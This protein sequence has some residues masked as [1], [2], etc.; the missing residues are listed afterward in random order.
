[1]ESLRTSVAF[2]G[3]QG[4]K[5]KVQSSRFKVCP[6]QVLI[7]WPL[8]SFQLDAR[9]S[10]LDVR[11]SMLDVRCSMFDARCS[12]LDV[13]CSM[14]DV[15]CSMFGTSNPELRTLNFEPSENPWVARRPGN[16]HEWSRPWTEPVYGGKPLT[17]WLAI[18]HTGSPPVR[19]EAEEAVR[20]IGTNSIPFL[21][22][23]LCAYD[24]ALKLR[25][26]KFARRHQNFV[27][28]AAN[29]PA[30]TAQVYAA[31]GFRVLG[32]NAVQA[33]PELVKILDEEISPM[34]QASTAV[35]FLWIGPPARAAVPSLL[36]GATATNTEVRF[37]S[38]WALGDIHA[39]PKKVL[40]VL[41]N[42][43]R[44]PHAGI[45]KQAIF[46]VVS[47]STDAGEMAPAISAL[48]SDP[49]KNVRDTARWALT[50]AAIKN[51]IWSPTNQLQPR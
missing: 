3:V 8:F 34:S 7:C 28:I 31:H 2:K 10:M 18:C 19:L 5:F 27:K 24:L 50:N 22:E 16:Q 26:R 11:C 30:W 44:D 48:L 23:M 14:F 32:T 20:R 21:L 37:N 51:V 38:I 6:L 41:T 9:C 36:R 49:D 45:R 12:M 29:T 35:A 15:R 25:T 39:E 33:V 4:S 43:L 42:A 17:V 1:V 46:S 47:F 13:R 40:P